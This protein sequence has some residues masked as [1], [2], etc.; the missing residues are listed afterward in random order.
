MTGV[1][2]SASREVNADAV[3]QEHLIGT[4]KEQRG[5]PGVQVGQTRGHERI[6]RVVTLKVHGR[7]FG[8]RVERENN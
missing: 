1:P 6:A 4:G 7:G 2:A 3:M 8:G 5:G